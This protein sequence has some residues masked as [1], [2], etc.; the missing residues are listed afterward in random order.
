MNEAMVKLVAMYDCNFDDLLS[1]TVDG[2]G[3]DLEDNVDFLITDP[4]YN[5]R[6][7]SSKENSEHD[8]FSR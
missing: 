5:I 1:T 4:P 2:D 7:D 8:Q 3:V 6:H